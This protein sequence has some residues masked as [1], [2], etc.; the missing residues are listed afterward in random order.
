V[1]QSD[2]RIPAEVLHKSAYVN[3]TPK[4][5]DFTSAMLWGI[6]I[7]DTRVRGY[8]NAQVEISRTQLTCRVEGKD[9]TLNDDKGHVRGG[10]YLRHPWFGT[11]EHDPI[12]LSYS[13]DR[14]AVILRVGRKPD[15]VWHFWA[16]S[17]RAIIPAGH[18]EG[19]RRIVGRK[20]PSQT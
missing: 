13:R 14:T 1:S 4:P 5:K 20:R 6:A 7:A 2:S 9:V 19:F 3:P 18:L 15:K 11:D 8:K 17:P 12:P 10:L 16:A